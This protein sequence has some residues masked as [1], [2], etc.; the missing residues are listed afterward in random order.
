MGMQGQYSNLLFAPSEK[1][2][3]TKFK[4]RPFDVCIAA[5]WRGEAD[6]NAFW[7]SMTGFEKKFFEEINQLQNTKDGIDV[8]L[9]FLAVAEYYNIPQDNINDFAPAL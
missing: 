4:D 5:Q 1:K 6:S 7:E 2:I 9:S 8:F 3:T